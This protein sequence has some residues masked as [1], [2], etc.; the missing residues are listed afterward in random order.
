V[1]D[2]VAAV[3]GGQATF[4]LVH[5]KQHV[6]DVELHKAE[7]ELGALEKSLGVK[8]AFLVRASV[9]NDRLGA[10]RP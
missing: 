1:R 6:P 4:T 8:I 2:V 5:D 9:E 10:D 3:G 7:L